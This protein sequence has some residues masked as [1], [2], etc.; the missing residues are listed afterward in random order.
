MQVFAVKDRGKLA[1]EVIS[2]SFTVIGDEPE[3]Y[4]IIE[5]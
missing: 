3:Q 2:Y 5:A 4:Q 1:K